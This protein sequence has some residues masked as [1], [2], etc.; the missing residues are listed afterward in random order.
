MTFAVCLQVPNH[1]R[2]KRYS[3]IYTNFIP[4]MV[5]LGID[6]KDSNGLEYQGKNK[7]KGAPYFAVDV[8]PK[9]SVKEEAEKLIKDLESKGMGFAQ[10]RVMDIEAKHGKYFDPL[11][12]LHRSI[13]C[14]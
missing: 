8:T 6:E 1:I 13:H 3:D 11:K 2:F 14:C 10:G 7:Y 12:L 9:K 4:Q 5:F